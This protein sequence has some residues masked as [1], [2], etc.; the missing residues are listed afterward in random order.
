MTLEHRVNVSEE[1][2]VE[3]EGIMVRPTTRA[4][5]IYKDLCLDV[6]T[7]S[8]LIK[9]DEEELIALSKWIRAA[10]NTAKR[11]LI[12]ARVFKKINQV[13]S[14]LSIL[15]AGISG[16]GSVMIETDTLS[17]RYA[18]V[19]SILS[20]VSATIVS[21][22]NSILDAPGKYREHMAAESDYNYLSTNIAVTLA[23]YEKETGMSD[24]KTGKAALRF[25]HLQYLHLNDTTPDA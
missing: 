19:T 23:T 4:L 12:K 21:I 5:D 16:I 3:S 1:N 9:E 20:F 18:I 15:F 2:S 25:F 11:H 22:N 10:E 8:I 17:P 13:L 14:F 24:F 6:K 7:H